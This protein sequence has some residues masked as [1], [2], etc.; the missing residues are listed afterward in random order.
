[1]FII[2]IQIL[3]I[4]AM[5]GVGVLATRRRWF[6]NDFSTH[7]SNLLIKVF[8]P[9]LLFSAILRNY[10]LEKI[11]DNWAL[12]AGAAAIII[13]GW[14][15]G[16]F[17][18]RLFVRHYHAPTRRAF[19]FTCT[20]NNYSFLP[21]MIIAGTTLGERG[22]AM[23]ALTTIASDTLMW[24]LGFQT[25]TGRKLIF[26]EL[27][28]MLLR[29]PILALFSA[30]ALLVLLHLFRVTPEML[31]SAPITRMPLDVLYKYLGNA[32]IPTS[33]LVCGMRLGQLQLKGLF[34]PLQWL[35][36]FFRMVLIPAMIL[37]LLCLVPLDAEMRMVFGVIALM[38]GAMVSVSMA[39]VYGGD[40]PFVSAMILNTH[41]A[42]IVTVPIGLWLLEKLC[43]L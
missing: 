26:S 14:I 10:T 38:P 1:M 23:V 31:L 8:Y 27:P 2:A 5:I 9:S 6:P 29:P 37:V 35:T 12:P 20:M 18:K 11:I 21:I 25:F 40:I 7:L 3:G 42:C 16:W 15:I 30:I 43:T 34:I 19:H 28:K 17:A 41:V 36:S 4:F 22:V 24:T 39:E 33:A 32:T 13:I